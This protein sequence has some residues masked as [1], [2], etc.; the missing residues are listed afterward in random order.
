MSGAIE[1]RTGKIPDRD[2][3]ASLYNSVQWAHAD[4]P[5]SLHKAVS[6][7][8]WVVTAWHED[9]LV[10]L[11]R[12]LTDGVFVAYF[13][14]MLVHPDYQHQGVGKELLDHYDRKFGEFQDQVAIKQSIIKL[15]TL[16]SARSSLDI[17]CQSVEVLN[18]GNLKA[19]H[20]TDEVG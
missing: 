13:Q 8:G 4:E 10:G 11:A 2:A 15:F 6:Q 9:T 16:K 3:L 1:Y 19:R 20:F 5:E 18:L 7:S 17:L 14:E 12:V